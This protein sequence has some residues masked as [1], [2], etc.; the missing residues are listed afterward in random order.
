MAKKPAG[1]SA[2]T[3]YDLCIIGGGVN[4]AGVARDAQG[5]GLSCVL[6]EQNDL[7]SATSSAATKLIHGGLRYLEYYEFRLVREALGE[8]ERLWKMAP[9]IIRPVRLI[10]PHQKGLRPRWLIRL[11]LFIYDHLGARKLLPATKT[12]NLRSS[13]YGKLLKDTFV[14]GFEF[15]DCWVEDA[16]LVVLN[17]MDAR[18]LGA[19]IL[20]QTKMENAVRKDGLWQVKVRGS[21]GGKSRT[22]QARALVNAGGPWVSEII[23][24]RLDLTEKGKV[25]LVKGSHIITRKLFDHD[26]LY[27]FQNSDGRIMFAIPYEGEFTLIG[28]TDAPLKGELEGIAISDAETDYLINE[29]NAYLAQPISRDDIVASYA[30]VR[31][32]YDDGADDASATTREYVLELEDVDGA[33]PVVNV[34]G[35]KLTTYRELAESVLEKLADYFPAMS[36]EWT[37]GSHLPGGDFA[38]DGFDDLVGKISTRYGFL[39]PDNAVRLARAYGTLA[40]EVL[41]DAA[42]FDDLGEDFGHGLSAREL[43]YLCEHEWAHCAKDVLWRR[44]KLELHLS[45]AQISRVEEWFKEER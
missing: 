1:A 31:P 34:F 14:T 25:R 43:V 10:L 45:A 44:S 17:A 15:S 2:D 5:R 12:I 26:R 19:Q 20:V 29:V 6:V 23:A 13:P 16:R 38:V 35:G 28:T 27:F 3:I 21:D 33:A 42:S 40:F 41:G 18:D 22:I 7:A 37:A 9:H 4:G 32:L 36:A 24:D 39:T 30:G 8:R 11:G